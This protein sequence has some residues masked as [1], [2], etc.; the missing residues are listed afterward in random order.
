MF[1]CSLANH[2][3]AK[4]IL[5]AMRREHTDTHSVRFS[6]SLQVMYVHTHRC[7]CVHAENAKSFD[8]DDDDPGA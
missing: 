3:M 7:L 8:D 1:G 6:A 4:S 2:V 5:C